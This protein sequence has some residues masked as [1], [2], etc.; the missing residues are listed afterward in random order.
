M[1]TQPALA[2][3]PHLRKMT[4]GPAGERGEHVD[5]LKQLSQIRE[6][7]LHD[8]RTDRLRLL[9]Q[10]PHS[11]QLQ[12]LSV[13]LTELNEETMSLLLHLP[14]LT[15]LDSYSIE[16]AAWVL[17][18][19]LP[20]LRHVELSL[21]NCVNLSSAVVS[22]LCDI[23]SAC[24]ALDHLTLL[25][26]RLRWDLE[27]GEAAVAQWERLL[28]SLPNL[29]RLDVVDFWESMLSVLPLHLPLLEHLSLSAYR[30]NDFSK[31]AHPNVR[32]LE[33]S[34]GP[35]PTPSEEQVRAWMGSERLPKLQ[36]Y[37]RHPISRA[38]V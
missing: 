6:L 29:R 34:L 14:T 13:P 2:Q 19:Q 16:R 7:T 11:L 28:S 12:S 21:H 27:S 1:H 22:S 36:R 24:R 15:S 3:L 33:L 38:V 8:N 18:P 31:V 32:T 26:L 25:H 9:C 10:P 35:M 5:A 4:L 30:R 37:I 20:H 23:L 17:L